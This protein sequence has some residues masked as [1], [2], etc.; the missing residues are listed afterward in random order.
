MGLPAEVEQTIE[1][2]DRKIAEL[3]RTRLS[4]IASFG[5]AT[6]KRTNARKNGTGKK[7]PE[8]AEKI[9]MFIRSNGSSTRKQLVQ[10]GGVPLGSFGYT[11]KH[12]LGNKQVKRIKGKK[13]Q[14][15]GQ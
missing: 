4:L 10:E 7:S 15:I 13:Y 1:Y 9:L 5:S 14:I 3:Q 8:N 11:I 6:T 12:L 2:I